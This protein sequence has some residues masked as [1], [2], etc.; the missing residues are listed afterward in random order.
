MEKTLEELVEG[1]TPIG[2]QIVVK[3]D[4]VKDETESGLVVVRNV[5][6]KPARGVV[7]KAGLGLKNGLNGETIGLVLRD[8]DRIVYYPH[9]VQ[10]VDI[11]EG[12]LP[13]IHEG[14]VIGFWRDES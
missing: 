14:D 12:T 1:F 4:A 7:L 3:P 8:G 5:E 2:N 6:K 10:M 13:I 9:A 11:G